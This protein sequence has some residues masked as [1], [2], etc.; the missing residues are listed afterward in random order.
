VGSRVPSRV[1]AA[2][3]IARLWTAHPFDVTA[4][5]V[6][7]PPPFNSPDYDAAGGRVTTRADVGTS[8]AKPA[9]PARDAAG[10]AASSVLPLVPPLERQDQLLE[11]PHAIAASSCCRIARAAMPSHR[12][13]AGRLPDEIASRN[14]QMKVRF[15]GQTSFSTLLVLTPSLPSAIKIAVTHN[16]IQNH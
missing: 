5:D 15:R 12:R 9:S 13:R 11:R 2:C 7:A 1:C 8:A 3:S 10:A 4:A 14:A 16:N 6:D